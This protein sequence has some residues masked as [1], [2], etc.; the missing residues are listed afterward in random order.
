[1][2]STR[3]SSKDSFISYGGNR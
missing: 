1:M 2:V 3:W